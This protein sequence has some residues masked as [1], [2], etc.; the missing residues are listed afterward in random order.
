MASRGKPNVIL[1]G[2]D[3]LRADHMSL[4]GYHRL[5]T[6]H[7]DKFAQEGAVFENVFSQHIPTSSGYSNMLTGFDC[8]GTGV[9]ALRHK[10][11][12]AKGIKP[13]SRILRDEGYNTTCVGFEG[14]VAAAG[15]NTYLDF[16]GWGSDAEGRA[17]KA[18]RLNDVTIPE[19]RR[20]AKSKK[21]FFLFMRHMDPHAP[22]R[23]PAPYE[24][25]FYGGNEFD[26]KNRSM[27]P[28]FAFKPFADFFATWMP[29]GVTDKDYMIAQ[30]DGELAYMDACIQNIL[31]EVAALELDDNTLIVITSDHGETLYD[32]DCYFD[33]HGIYDC[34]LHVPLLFRLPGRVPAGLRLSAHATLKSVTP[35]ILGILGIKTGI[36]F[37]GQNLY[38]EMKGRRRKPDSEFYITECTWMRKHGWRTPE[39]KLI[40][41]LEPDFHF[42]PEIE[43]YNLVQDPEE[44]N[45]LA[46]KEKAVVEM[47]TD[48]MNAWIARREKKT[49]RT[50]PMYT[51]LDW[52]KGKGVSGPFTS[53]QQAYDTLHI[54]SVGKAR[55]LQ[56]KLAAKKK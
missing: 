23:P 33:H 46:S 45:N 14:N 30:Y 43:L 54:G 12:L 8:F 39:W 44:N 41:A 36:K 26:R 9:V 22:Y 3:S 28:V 20:L 42:K 19:L 17:H 38:R 56:Q 27:D 7:I 6:P 31:A 29:E 37:D 40:R 50:N 10:G 47:L 51:N 2:I 32:H 1:F 16:D 52:H 11:P 55:A 5:T 13:L 15:F 21:P 25:A 53:S 18:E 48:R 4:Y 49:G 35:S 24:R 34:T